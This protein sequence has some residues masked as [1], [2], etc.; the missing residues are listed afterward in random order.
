MQTCKDNWPPFNS[1]IGIVWSRGQITV[2]AI[3]MR[4]TVVFFFR[5]SF[6]N[7]LSFDNMSHLQFETLLA[8]Y[9][10]IICQVHRSLIN[11]LNCGLKW[12]YSSNCWRICW[13]NNYGLVFRQISLTLK[14]QASPGPYSGHGHDWHCRV[15]NRRKCVI[16]LFVSLQSYSKV[17]AVCRVWCI[18]LVSRA[19]KSLDYRW[20]YALGTG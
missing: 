5:L 6:C 13:S 7:S 10:P 14:T 2:H 15:L 8:N 20:H 3:Y 4:I 18:R 19:F 9:E 17:W 16:F 11:E 1:W 12:T